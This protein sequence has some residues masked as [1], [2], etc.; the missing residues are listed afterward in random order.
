MEKEVTDAILI[1]VTTIAPDTSMPE[2]AAQTPS[3]EQLMNKAVAT[4]YV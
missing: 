3:T 4:V 2:I 1:N